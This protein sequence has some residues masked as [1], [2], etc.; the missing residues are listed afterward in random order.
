MKTSSY[1]G[2]LKDFEMCEVLYEMIDRFRATTN[3]DYD[4]IQIVMHPSVFYTISRNP[5]ITQDYLKNELKFMGIDIILDRWVSEDTIIVM[6]KPKLHISTSSP[7][8]GNSYPYLDD[9]FR[10]FEHYQLQDDV[11]DAVRYG[12]EYMGWLRNSIDMFRTEKEIMLRKLQIKKVIYHAPATIVYWEDGDKTVVKCS[13]CQG[14]N[15]C[16][17]C[18]ECHNFDKEKGLA[19]AMCKRM[20]DDRGNYNDIFRKW[21]K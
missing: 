2:G 17:V 8:F 5:S 7:I 13:E 21:C 1:V 12:W 19:M 3:C 15:D 11:P 14:R 16:S 10:G 9:I 6:E 20:A 18:Y 4:D